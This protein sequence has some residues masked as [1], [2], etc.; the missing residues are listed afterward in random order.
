MHRSKLFW[1]RLT[2]V[3]VTALLVSWVLFSFTGFNH[4]N[5][6]ADTAVQR[7]QSAQS[8]SSEAGSPLSELTPSQRERALY[9][10]YRNLQKIREVAQLDPRLKPFL[11]QTL[12]PLDR[13][14]AKDR[15]LVRSFGDGLKIDQ[16]MPTREMLD[17]AVANGSS[18]FV[19]NPLA[20]GAVRYGEQD[21]FNPGDVYVKLLDDPE[22]VEAY[23]DVYSVSYGNADLRPELGLK[24]YYLSIY[25]ED[26][27]LVESFWHVGGAP[28]VSDFVVMISEEEYAQLERMTPEERRKWIDDFNR[29]ADRLFTKPVKRTRV[30]EENWREIPVVH[31]RFKSLD[32]VPVHLREKA[33][34]LGLFP[35]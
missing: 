33:K 6:Q 2:A 22:L 17:Q 15:E 13:M 26:G 1:L 7:T 31:T 32:D 30:T 9:Y 25:G 27:V 23:R 19:F 12:V 29:W 8:A 18:S 10:M 20:G 35:G 14:G 5:S 11:T 24:V 16:F 21:S 4:L 34:E 28:R 3:S